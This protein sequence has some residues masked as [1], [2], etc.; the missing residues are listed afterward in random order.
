[1]RGVKETNQ[2]VAQM[3]ERKL[4]V[5]KEI[6]EEAGMSISHVY[7]DLVFLN[8]NA[9]L[10][11]FTEDSSTVLLRINREAERETVIGG[12]ALLKQAALK[13]EMQFA[14][15][16]SYA[17]AQDGQEQVRIEFFT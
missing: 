9:I 17:L 3:K 13:R 11:Q 5:V 15:S 1:L 14:E 16:G 2:L 7:E 4:G 10:L 6:V 12:V 8:H